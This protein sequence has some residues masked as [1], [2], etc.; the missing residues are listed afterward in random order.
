M[1]WRYIASN[2]K[3]HLDLTT[4]VLDIGER[5]HDERGVTSTQERSLLKVG[6]FCSLL[7]T[8]NLFAM[9][10]SSSYVREIN[11]Q[12]ML[13]VVELFLGGITLIGSL[14]LFAKMLVHCFITPD[15]GSATKIIWTVVFLSLLWV[16]GCLY[17]FLVYGRKPRQVAHTCR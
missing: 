16:G 13:Y 15:N 8:L 12:P 6:V 7:L 9:D 10:F 2:L 17:Y 4:T 14:Y 5:R 11:S 1:V 3:E